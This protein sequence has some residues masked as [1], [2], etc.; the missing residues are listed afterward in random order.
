MKYYTDCLFCHCPLGKIA[1]VRNAFCDHVCKNGYRDWKRAQKLNRY[2]TKQFNEGAVRE[3][4]QPPLFE[5]GE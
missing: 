5:M 2:A 3:Y 1:N 4:V